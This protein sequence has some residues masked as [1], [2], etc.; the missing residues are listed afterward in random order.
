MTPSAWL[1]FGTQ[2]TTQQLPQK[3]CCCCCCCVNLCRN[4][5]VNRRCSQH[6]DARQIGD[7]THLWYHDDCTNCSARRSTKDSCMLSVSRL[8]PS[9]MNLSF[10][11][12][13]PAESPNLRSPFVPFS[14]ILSAIKTYRWY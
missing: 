14:S 9:A 10:E 5:R 6:Y 4:I 7:T 3:S 8:S 13:S 1:I 11:F 12:M 2:K